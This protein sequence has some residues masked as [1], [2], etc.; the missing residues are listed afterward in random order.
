MRQTIACHEALSRIEEW[1]QVR[2]LD[3]RHERQS[4]Y[5]AVFSRCGTWRYLLWRMHHPRGRL[6]G[7]GLLNPSTAD[8]HRDDPTIARCH[9]L[10]RKLGYP[11]LIVWNLFAL[12]ATDPAALRKSADPVG[13][14]ND[15]AIDLAL[16]LCP[17]TV[18]AWGNHGALGGRGAEVLAHCEVSGTRLGSL[19]MTLR[20]EPRHPLYLPGDVRPRPLRRHG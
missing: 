1:M 10:A 5:G 19:G 7:M 4:G 17:R 18:L 11:G 15:A 16:S 2:G 12:R 3:Y 8:E 6:L 9:G 13:P 20:G 14:Q